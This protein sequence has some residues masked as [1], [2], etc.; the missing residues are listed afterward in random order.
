LREDREENE[1]QCSKYEQTP[2]HAV[3]SNPFR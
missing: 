3:H 1:T 2:S